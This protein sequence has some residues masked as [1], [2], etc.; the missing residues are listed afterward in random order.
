LDPFCGVAVNLPERTVVAVA[1]ERERH[2]AVRLDAAGGRAV[3][4]AQSPSAEAPEAA[5]FKR[6]PA[7]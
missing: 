7:M 1:E 5:D 6:G 2:V 3:V 4:G